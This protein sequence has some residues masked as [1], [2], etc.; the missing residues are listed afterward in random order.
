MLARLTADWW[1][2][3]SFGAGAAATVI[4]ALS[5]ARLLILERRR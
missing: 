3:A 5:L 1:A 2:G 4:F